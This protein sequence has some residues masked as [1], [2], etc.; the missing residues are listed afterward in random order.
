MLSQLLGRIHHNKVRIQALVDP[1][2]ATSSCLG[3]H[4]NFKENQKVKYAA[5]SFINKA[6]TWWNTQVQTRDHEA[7]VGMTW[8]EF[9]ALFMEEFCP[10]NEM[11]KLESEF[12]N[13][14]MVGANH[15]GIEDSKNKQKIEDQEIGGL[16]TSTGLHDL[17]ESCKNGTTNQRKK[18]APTLGL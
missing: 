8:V 16:K 13:H 14:T 2:V 9:K 4:L 18:H 3:Q 17:K 7:A 15:A 11:E 5:S 6:L 1:W 12:W 10:S